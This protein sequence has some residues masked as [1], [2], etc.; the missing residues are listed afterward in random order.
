[1]KL[2]ITKDRICK[3]CGDEIIPDDESHLSGDC[4]HR[5]VTAPDSVYKVETELPENMTGHIVVFNDPLLVEVWK[6]VSTGG[7]LFP[8]DNGEKITTTIKKLDRV[9]KCKYM[10]VEGG[11]GAYKCCSGRMLIGQFFETIQ[12]VIDNKP[13][14][15]GNTKEYPSGYIPILFTEHKK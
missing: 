10:R 6:V 12:D 4:K 9:A 2:K 8:N 3:H 5:L 14:E 1:M 13:C 7:N 11:F 15:E